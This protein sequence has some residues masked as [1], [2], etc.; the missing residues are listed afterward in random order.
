MSEPKKCGCG[1]TKNAEGLCDGSHNS[2]PKKEIPYNQITIRVISTK[3]PQKTKFVFPQIANNRQ[4][5]KN[6]GFVISDP[7][8]EAKMEAVRAKKAFSENGKPK[9]ADKE[10]FAPKVEEVKTQEPVSQ[11]KNEVE[12]PA[13]EGE[14]KTKRTR[15]TK[16]QIEADKLKQTA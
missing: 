6:M 9:E 4:L 16:A 13:I 15:R 1:K 2:I 8:Y 12:A 7:Q 14:P 10:A 3:E 5:M 11:P